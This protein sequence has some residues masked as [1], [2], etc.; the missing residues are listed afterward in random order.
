MVTIAQ[1]IDRETIVAL[2]AT[3]L[4]AQLEE[5]ERPVEWLTQGQSRI[6]SRAAHELFQSYKKLFVRPKEQSDLP[7]ETILIP[8]PEYPKNPA[9]KKQMMFIVNE[10]INAFNLEKK[11][12]AMIALAK[13][14]LQRDSAQSKEIY[15]GIDASNVLQIIDG[16]EYMGIDPKNINLRYI[17]HKAGGLIGFFLSPQ[18]MQ[19]L[20]KKGIL[21]D[22]GSGN[23]QNAD[24]SQN[25]FLLILNEYES[26]S[27]KQIKSERKSESKAERQVSKH[28]IDGCLDGLNYASLWINC[29][30]NIWNPTPTKRLQFDDEVD[31]FA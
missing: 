27:S 30:L 10:T 14:W 7:Q 18:D 26:N 13:C 23:I 28:F 17:P 1:A 21:L 15:S 2:N 5:L 16:F 22:L 31:N 12:P 3:S 25:S 8:V 24:S 20:I 6:T 19:E 4:T 11:R 29:V 9:R